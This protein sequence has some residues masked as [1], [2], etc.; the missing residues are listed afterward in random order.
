MMVLELH[1]S[2]IPT[3]GQALRT[4]HGH[5]E[6]PIWRFN[7]SEI[8]RPSAVFV[9]LVTS[10]HIAEDGTAPRQR[11]PPRSCLLGGWTRFSNCLVL[12]TANRVVNRDPV[13][14]LCRL[15]R[16]INIRLIPI[17][18][19]HRTRRDIRYQTLSIASDISKPRQITRRTSRH[20]WALGRSPACRGGPRPLRSLVAV[21]RPGQG[22][23]RH[24]SGLVSFGRAASVASPRELLSGRRRDPLCVGACHG[25]TRVWSL[26]IPE[27]VT[28]MKEPHFALFFGAPETD[29]GFHGKPKRSFPFPTRLLSDFLAW[30]RVVRSRTALIP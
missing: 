23:F 7:S 4:G 18:H 30:D 20:L 5:D 11:P 2:A 27:L 26:G 13:D 17:D 3:P 9:L 12:Q 25:T 28:D 1:Q 22:I 10:S 21:R 14:P 16:H 19:R 29:D 8:S 6:I 15:P 24:F